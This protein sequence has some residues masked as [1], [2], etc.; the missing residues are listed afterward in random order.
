VL[1]N[2]ALLRL[3]W[4][5]KGILSIKCA[6]ET[7]LSLLALARAY[8]VA[9]IIIEGVMSDNLRDGA[10]LRQI[11]LFCAVLGIEAVMTGVNSQLAV[12]CGTEVK[13]SLRMKLLSKVLRL[14]PPYVNEHRSGDLCSTLVSRIEALDPYYSSYIPALWC[15]SYSSSQAALPPCMHSS[16]HG[17]W[18]SGVWLP[19]L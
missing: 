4:D 18:V 6:T 15:L 2:K 9:R 5:S 11:L 10:L 19:L 8:I 3:V 14:G 17:T 1:I 12:K 7:A 13:N 16:T